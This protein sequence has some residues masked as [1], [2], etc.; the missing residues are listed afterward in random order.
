MARR[1]PFNY[2]FVSFFKHKVN[3]GI[4][5]ILFAVLAMVVANSPW[6]TYYINFLEYPLSLKFGDFNLLSHHGI[7]LS[8]AD[9]INDCLMAIFFFH[10]GL[11]IKREIL[12]GELSS[13]KKAALPIIAAFGGM[14]VP[15]LIFLI[16]DHTAPGS[17]GAAIPMATDIAFS[18]G[19]L[20]LLGKRVPL[21]LKIFLTAFA[22]A[23]DIGGIL[24]IAVFYA[25]NLNYIALFSAFALIALLYVA[26]RLRIQWKTL[27]AL[28]GIAVWYL[29]MQSGVHSTVAGVLVAFTIPAVPRMDIQKYINRI[30]R[31]VNT[32]PVRN[33]KSI[34]LTNDQIRELKIIEGNSNKVIS[35]LQDMEDRLSGFVN[36]FI[37]P[38]FAFANS[39]VV[40]GSNGELFGLVTFGVAFGLIIGKPIG[41]FSFTWISVKLKL[42]MLPDGVNWKSLWGVCCMGGIGFTVSLFIANLSFGTAYPELLNQAKLGI[43]LGTLVSG[44]IGYVFLNKA[45]PKNKTE[46][47]ETDQE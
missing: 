21:G 38:L 26:N 31:S 13:V 42:V 14:I 9:F 47:A 22:V 43:V 15:V 36:Y 19:A 37:L 11:E 20:S 25:S 24:V 45:L 17:R 6:S 32:F 5:L 7:G 29:F 4:L 8:M 39:G 41:L 27:Y 16:F 34:V 44:M 35:P 1:K 23:D 40:F 10:V 46:D 28:V 33:I 3:G 18:L 2:S 12:V 30:R